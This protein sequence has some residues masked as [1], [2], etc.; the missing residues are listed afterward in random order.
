M[1]TKI[2]KPIIP[3]PKPKPQPKPMNEIVVHFN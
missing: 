1:K 2:K 3:K